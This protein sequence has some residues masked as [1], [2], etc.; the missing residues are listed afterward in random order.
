[1]YN[2]GDCLIIGI[3][4]Q[5]RRWLQRESERVREKAR[6]R[7]GVLFLF[8][9]CS[10]V[11]QQN[12]HPWPPSAF[13]QILSITQKAAALYFTT[14]DDTEYSR[15]HKHMWGFSLRGE[16]EGGLKTLSR[17]FH[18]KGDLWRKK[19]MSTLQR[20]VELINH[21][22]SVS[23]HLSKDWSGKVWRWGT[24]TSPVPSWSSILEWDGLI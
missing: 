23:T 9:S 1:M 12:W 13:S 17:H 7:E 16:G 3:S 18:W 6:E 2:Q 4:I 19:K 21:T 15:M 8:K 20:F 22:L 10:S 24:K 11:L 5:T 14:Y